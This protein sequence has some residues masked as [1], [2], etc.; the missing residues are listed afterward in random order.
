MTITC[1]IFQKR[2]PIHKLITLM[3]KMLIQN[4][5]K[6]SQGSMSERL[7][8]WRT[9][10][11]STHVMQVVPFASPCWLSS[12]W[13]NSRKLWVKYCSMCNDTKPSLS[14]SI[15]G[16][17]WIWIGLCQMVVIGDC[18]YIYCKTTGRLVRY[19]YSRE[20]LSASPVQRM[21]MGINV[22]RLVS[23]E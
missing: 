22:S 7:A 2:Y 18:E 4:F 19:N 12:C 9:N 10:M 16:R 5:N 17:H 23:L 15:H 13:M 8:A 11:S 1:G 6:I 14:L 3:Q 21:G 20:H